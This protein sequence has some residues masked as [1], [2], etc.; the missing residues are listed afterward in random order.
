MLLAPSLFTGSLS[1]KVQIQASHQLYQLVLPIKCQ[2]IYKF[3]GKWCVIVVHSDG[4]NVNDENM[5]EEELC[6]LGMSDTVGWPVA[7]II[8]YSFQGLDAFHTAVSYWERALSVSE[9]GGSG[10]FPQLKDVLER[11]HELQGS[12]LQVGGMRLAPRVPAVDA[13][14]IPQRPDREDDEISTSSVDSFQSAPEPDS[15]SE[16]C[17]PCSLVNGNVSAWSSSQ[18]RYNVGL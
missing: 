11:A 7:H 9:D 15:D 12:L 17:M 2:S 10:K 8:V 3:I 5:C 16:V 14:V 1:N 13:L 18:V 6:Q 4:H